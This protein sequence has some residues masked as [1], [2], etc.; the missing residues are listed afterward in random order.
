MDEP[1]NKRLLPQPHRY[2][3]VEKVQRNL[4]G[5]LAIAS[6]LDE[7]EKNLKEKMVLP[8]T[9]GL[10]EIYPRPED[11]VRDYAFLLKES[12]IE[13]AVFIRGHDEFWQDKEGAGWS[14]ILSRACGNTKYQAE[15]PENK[16]LKLKDACDKLIH[17]TSFTIGTVGNP[18]RFTAFLAGTKHEKKWTAELDVVEFCWI[19]MTYIR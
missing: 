8:K 14:K 6:S 10:V 1:F 12:L 15:N 19:G 16:P 5:I 9:S 2:P 13:T 3:H 7:I 4:Y 11:V 18:A 17:H